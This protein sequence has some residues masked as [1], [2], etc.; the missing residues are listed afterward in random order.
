MCWQLC[1]ACATSGDGSN[2]QTCQ[3]NLG[4]LHVRK[5]SL[6]LLIQIQF[7]GYVLSCSIFL[8]SSRLL[9]I[10]PSSC[11]DPAMCWFCFDEDRWWVM[12]AATVRA[13]HAGYS[14]H[15]CTTVQQKM[16]QFAIPCLHRRDVTICHHYVDFNQLKTLCRRVENSSICWHSVVIPAQLSV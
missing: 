16:I 13:W 14:V 15:E 8:H 11:T 5:N 1:Q 9:P 6:K 12:D 2:A 3:I 4:N 10:F 7:G